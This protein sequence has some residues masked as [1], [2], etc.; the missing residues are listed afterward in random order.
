M[1]RNN[2]HSAGRFKRFRFYAVKSSQKH[3]KFL[4]LFAAQSPRTSANPAPER[5][6][7]I[8]FASANGAGV[9]VGPK[10]AHRKICRCRAD[11]AVLRSHL[12]DLKAEAIGEIYL[13]LPWS[14][15]GLKAL[16]GDLG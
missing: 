3:L 13:T 10:L 16:K 15:E 1:G 2:N 9:W 8:G 11:E 12:D 14:D 5:R 4:V 7:L 6:F